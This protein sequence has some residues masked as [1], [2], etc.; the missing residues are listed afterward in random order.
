MSGLTVAHPAKT[1]MM[2]SNTGRGVFAG[3]HFFL[4]DALLEYKGELVTDE[5]EE[6]DDTFIY[7]LKHKGKVYW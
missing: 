7:Q 2:H 1:V 3:K 5:P 6:S 4:G